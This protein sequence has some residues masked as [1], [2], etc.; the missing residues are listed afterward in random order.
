MNNGCAVH[1]A[2]R[3]LGR[4][5][6]MTSSSGKPRRLTWTP[7]LVSQFWDGVAQSPL[8]RLSFSRLAGSSLTLAVSHH[9]RPDATCLDFGAGSGD[10]IAPLLAAGC[11]VAA[12]EQ[13]PERVAKLE[14]RFRDQPRFSGVVHP[15]SDRTFDVV[16]AAEVMEHVLDEQLEP[17]LQ[18][19]GRLLKPGGLLVVTT[20]NN[21]DL[22]LGM[23]YSPE[24]NTLF[25]RWQHVRSFTAETL[26]ALWAAHG[27]DALA[28]HRLEFNP[29]LL[30]PLADKPVERLPDYLRDLR[31]DRS[32]RMGSETSI[33]F[34]GR[35]RA[36]Q[37]TQEPRIG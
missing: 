17:T 29:Q 28:V 35:R 7:Q 23:C 21:E 18:L 15:D 26:S 37:R 13:A 30:A 4:V 27:V 6:C 14:A 20:P 33:L 12:L 3:A 11:R 25:H 16:F 8:E 19:I 31:R 24:T 2:G 1:A 5:I 36:G 9:L 10:L 34:L 22:D 32:M